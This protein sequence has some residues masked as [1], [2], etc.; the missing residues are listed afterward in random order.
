MRCQTRVHQS[1]RAGGGH[2]AG[3]RPQLVP[4]A[5]ALL[6]VPQRT[7]VLLARR[8]MAQR[9][10]HQVSGL[11]VGHYALRGSTGSAVTTRLDR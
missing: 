11:Y 3:H 5:L 9:Q 10:F 7:G 6:D 1:G 4:A 8:D 2:H